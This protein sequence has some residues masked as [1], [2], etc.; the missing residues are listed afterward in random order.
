MNEECNCSALFTDEEQKCIHK[1]VEVN[2]E[3]SSKSSN[4]K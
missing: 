1:K 2:R 4:I 3:K